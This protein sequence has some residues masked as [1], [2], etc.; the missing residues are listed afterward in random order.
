MFTKNSKIEFVS[1]GTDETEAIGKTLGEY[2]DGHDVSRAVI[3]MR[4]EMGV[5]KTAFVRGFA[6]SVG[7][8]SVKSPTYTVMNHYLGKRNIFHFD[9]YRIKDEDDLI[10][11]G[12]DDCIASD[13]Y[14]LI[15]WSENIEYALPRD[16]I[17]VT[18]SRIPGS[19]DS[20]KITIE[21]MGK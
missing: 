10:S 9:M 5:G 16:I 20:R 13:G 1:H 7:I 12:Y 19:D 21:D 3:A 17:S 4:G 18:I 2:L 14:T 11:V 6:A 15:E 8:C